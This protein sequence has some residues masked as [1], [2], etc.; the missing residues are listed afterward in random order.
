[1][2]SNL[3]KV[4]VIVADKKSISKGAKKLKSAQSNITAKIQQLEKSL[5]CKLFHRVPSGILLTKEGEKL[6]FHAIE[7]IKKI[8]LA[9]LDMKNILLE[10]KLIVGSTEANAITNIVDFLINID[11]DFP[12]IQLEL[13]TNTTEDIKQ[14]LLE[15]KIDIGFISGIPNEEEFEVLNKIDETLVLVES[16]QHN[17][18]NVFLSFKKGCAYSAFAQNYFEKMNIEINKRFEF[19]SYETILGCIEVGIGKSILPL[20]IVKKLKYEDKLNIFYL[21]KEL[22]FMPTYLI[23]RKDNKPKIA[24]YLKVINF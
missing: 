22:S 1:M 9:T 12:N 10:Q 6:Y 15:Y 13:I 17:I 3:L 2:D 21:K 8:E 20:S 4:F 18:S 24:E 19:A 7:I 5:N 23:C 16:K 11:K 14:M